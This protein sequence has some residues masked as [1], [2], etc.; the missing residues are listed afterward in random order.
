MQK[1]QKIFKIN[2]VKS[3]HFSLKNKKVLLLKNENCVPLFAEM[4]QTQFLSK[5]KRYFPLMG[6]LLTNSEKSCSVKIKNITIHIAALPTGLKR[7]IVYPIIT[8][9][10]PL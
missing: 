10:S 5:L 1:K 9:T 4:P 8:E 3:L 6:K 2:T 7:Y